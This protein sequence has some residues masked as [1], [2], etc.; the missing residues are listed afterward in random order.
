MTCHS[1]KNRRQCGACHVLY[2][3]DEIFRTV[4][5]IF[6]IRAYALTTKFLTYP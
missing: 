4:S 6:L 2:I 3:V 1:A 5:A